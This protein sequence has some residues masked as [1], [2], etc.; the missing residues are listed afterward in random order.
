M[1]SLHP[2]YGL[3]DDLRRSAVYYAETTGVRESAYLHNV[4]PASIYRW[5][6]R[7]AKERRAHAEP[8]VIWVNEYKGGHAWFAYK[9]EQ[10]AKDCAGRDATRIAVK[11]AE[12]RRD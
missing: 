9:T 11:Y 3:T 10:A 7:F 2:D 12:V 1:S 5:R 4:S 6:K 8:G